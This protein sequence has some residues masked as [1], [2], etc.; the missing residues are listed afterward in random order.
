MALEVEQRNRQPLS[1]RRIQGI[2]K[3]QPAHRHGSHYELDQQLE[4]ARHPAFVLSRDL[5]VVVDEAQRTVAHG[6]EQR[7]PYQRAG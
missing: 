2:A 6:D 3:E 5:Q 1:H 7:R 4:L